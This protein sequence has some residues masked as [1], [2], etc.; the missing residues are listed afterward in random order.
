ME[1]VC[2]GGGMIIATAMVQLA[3]EHEYIGIVTALAV[4]ARNIGGAVGQV[5]Y[6]SIF[7]GRLKSNIIKYVVGP[8][9]KAGVPAQEIEAVLEAISSSDPASLVGKLTP[10]QMEIG[11]EGTQQ[12]F[13]HSLRVVYLVS[14][15][16]GVVGT[17]FVCFCRNVDHLLTNKVDIQLDEGAKLRAVTDTG[18]GHIIPV[19]EQARH[20]RRWLGVTVATQ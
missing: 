19:E 16:F 5:I 2:V 1:G 4:A 8:L 17:V 13:V 20:N 7:T 9:L 3:V 10:T 6:V 12:A 11:V 18:K 15:A 14:I